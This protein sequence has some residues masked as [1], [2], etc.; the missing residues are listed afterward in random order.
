[1]KS[2]KS[3]I[4]FFLLLFILKVFTGC[5]SYLDLYPETQ[6]TQGVYYNNETEFI[7]AADDVYRQLTRVYNAGSVSD[8]FGE[9]FSD[10]VEIVFAAGGNSWPEDINTHRIKTD[11]GKIRSA[12]QTAYSALFL[13]NNV[14]DQL[15]KTSVEFET[16][17]LK[18]RLR[19]EAVFVRSVIFF[20]LVQAF[21][22]IPMP[23]NAV[24]PDESYKYLRVDKKTVY[25]QIID[26]LKSCKDALPPSYTGT[27][28]GRATSY[29]VSAFLAK[30]Y[31]LNSDHT[32]AQTELKRIIDSGFYSL[33]ANNN[34]VIDE[35]DYAYL[36]HESTKNCKESIFEI[37]Y[38]AGANQVNSGHQGAYTPFHHAFHLPGSTQTW[39]GEGMNTP[40]DDIIGEYEPG[41]PR[42]DISIYPGYVNLD[43]DLFV[44]YPFTMKFYDP[45]WQN[46]GQN[47]EAVRYADILLLYS[48]VTNDPS[49][50]NQVRARVGLPAFGSAGYPSEYDTLEK[51][52]EHER[53]VELAFEFHRMFDLV[54]TGRALTVLNSKGFNL[55]ANSLLFP[56]PQIEIDINP[57]LTQNDAYK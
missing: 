55:S 3:F 35:S 12:W 37:Q 28:I 57:G 23:L 52:I 15:D 31:L 20:N 50:L 1:M 46:P 24:S 51:A 22:D 18:Q 2:Y 56:L 25:Q 26:D 11:N 39:R 43:N 33:D 29:A 21:G 41:D 6:L 42:K 19:A 14:I 49:Y 17:N 45:N 36:F 13:T 54:R 44:D 27:N 47:F 40:N 8:L 5:E 9:L 30:T 34:G 10:N 16:P 48:E 38:L 7:R 32:S 53:R 4:K